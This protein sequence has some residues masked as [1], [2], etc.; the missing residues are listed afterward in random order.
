MSAATDA[1]T[2]AA[3]ATTDVVEKI[4]DN[5]AKTLTYVAVVVGAA[6]IVGWAVRNFGERAMDA[7]DAAGL[8]APPAYAQVIPIRDDDQ[9]D[10]VDQGDGD[11]TYAEQA[12]GQWAQ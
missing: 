12:D 8:F 11:D 4:V 7:A 9:G 3:D 1:A 10:D 2:A 5:S 6:W